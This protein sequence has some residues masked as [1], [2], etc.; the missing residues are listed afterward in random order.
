M[1]SASVIRAARSGVHP[2]R[3][4][5]VDWKRGYSWVGCRDGTHP[6]APGACLEAVETVDTLVLLGLV[7]KVWVP[8]TPW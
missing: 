5:A 3:R 8:A 1:G 2:W 4:P 6:G 7:R